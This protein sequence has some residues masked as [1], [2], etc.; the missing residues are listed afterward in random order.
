MTALASGTLEGGMVRGT[1]CVWLVGEGGQSAI[2]W[3]AGYHARVHP[4][5]LLNSQ[6]AVVA[7]GGDLIT[8]A[9][10]EGSVNPRQACMLNQ[11]RA[12]YITGSVT[13]RHQ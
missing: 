8:F 6:G 12:F 10:G 9:G 1:F 7:R 5:E 2:V 13:A 11:R 3:P 4:L